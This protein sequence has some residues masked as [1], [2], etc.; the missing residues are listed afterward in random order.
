MTFAKKKSGWAHSES[1]YSGGGLRDSLDQELSAASPSVIGVNARVLTQQKQASCVQPPGRG[2]AP[3][4]L[5]EGGGIV[6]LLPWE[7][8][9]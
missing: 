2:A 8:V 6:S 4:P 1:E 7:I 5:R 9:V 3:A